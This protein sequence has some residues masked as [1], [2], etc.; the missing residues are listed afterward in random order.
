MA[1]RIYADRAEYYDVLY[2]GKEYGQETAFVVDAFG[3]HATTDTRTALVIGCGTGNHTPHLVDSGFDTTSVDPSEDMLRFARKKSDATFKQAELPDL[4]A[5]DGT[6]GLVWLPFTVINHLDQ[7]AVD[8]SLDRIDELLADE[9]VLVFD[10]GDFN[11]EDDTAPP[12]V[13]SA[14]GETGDVGRVGQLHHEDGDR[15]TFES[16][17][18]TQDGFFADTHTLY[19]HTADAI[20]DLL[21]DHGF[22]WRRH[23]EGYGTDSSKYQGT[24]YVCWRE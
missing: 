7:A 12:F 4:D 21:A 19:A 20:E 23:D 6:Y 13:E 16:L 15:V 22:A 9:G 17:V 8:A 10:N 11:V 1:E 2:S 24:V 14:A 5:V 18:F 3:Q